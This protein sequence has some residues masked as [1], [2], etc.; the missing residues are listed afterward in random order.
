MKEENVHDPKFREAK[1]PQGDPTAPVERL[2][3]LD[4]RTIVGMGMLLQTPR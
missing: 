4:S 1:P 3:R 2:F